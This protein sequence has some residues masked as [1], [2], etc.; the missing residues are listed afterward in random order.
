MVTKKINTFKPL[1]IFIKVFENIELTEDMK[2][3]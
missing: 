1:K 3:F 2:L